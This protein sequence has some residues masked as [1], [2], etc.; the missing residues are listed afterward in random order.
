LL[1]LRSQCEEF[2][3]LSAQHCRTVKKMAIVTHWPAPKHK[4]ENYPPKA[5]GCARQN[6]A[7]ARCEITEENYSFSMSGIK[8]SRVE[9]KTDPTSCPTVAELPTSEVVCHDP[10][11]SPRD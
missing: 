3:D 2:V 10:P 7:T 6:D 1:K 11:K 4:L 8:F 5:Q 9:S